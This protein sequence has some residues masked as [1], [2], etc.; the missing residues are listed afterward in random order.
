ME[1]FDVAK[2]SVTQKLFRIFE[3]GTLFTRQP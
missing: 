3:K 1:H 2:D